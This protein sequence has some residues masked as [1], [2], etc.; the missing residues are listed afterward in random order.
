[1]GRFFKWKTVLI[2]SVIAIPF[3]GLGFILQQLPESM[4]I[5]IGE[6]THLTSKDFK[7]MIGVVQIME[8]DLRLFKKWLEEALESKTLSEAS[9]QRVR[10]L[11]R[12]VD[13]ELKEIKHIMEETGSK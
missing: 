13:N 4:I 11:I 5:T 7:E 3:V 12:K 1:M 8:V 6:P 9:K 10:K 2:M